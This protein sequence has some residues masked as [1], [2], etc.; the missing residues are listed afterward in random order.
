ME[1]LYTGRNHSIS[2]ACDFYGRAIGSVF[3]KQQDTNSSMD[4]DY[5]TRVAVHAFQ[6]SDPQHK[7]GP[8]LTHASLIKFEEGYASCHD[9]K[10][11]S[12]C[13]FF[14]ANEAARVHSLRM[15]APF[16]NPIQKCTCLCYC[17]FSEKTSI[18]F[19]TNESHHANNFQLV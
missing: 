2:T 13:D 5:C 7:T 16:Q 3:E 15:C 18:Y 17:N 12:F 10:R 8:R 9:G 4:S 14:M 19:L 1:T 6:I 11:K